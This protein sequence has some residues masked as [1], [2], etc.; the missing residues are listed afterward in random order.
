MSP[1]IQ[2]QIPPHIRVKLPGETIE[3]LESAL[4]ELSEWTCTLPK[5][6]V[7][8]L[9]AIPLYRRLPYRVKE[10][11]QLDLNIVDALSDI[12][13]LL[14]SQ[15]L[16]KSWRTK[17]IAEGL[18]YS[19]ETWNLT[20]AASAA[21]AL[22]ETACAWCV[23]SGEI[24][25]T[26]QKQRS[27]QIR[28]AQDAL[29]IRNALYDESF[30][31]TWGTRQP[32]ML[33]SKN[34]HPARTLQRKNIITMIQKA[35]KL[36][37]RERL[38][39]GYEVLCDAVHPS[40]GANEVF[41]VEGGMAPEIKRMRVLLN[42]ESVGQIDATDTSQVRPG[43][44]LSRIILTEGAWALRSLVSSFKV[45]D[46][47]CRDIFMTAKLYL[48]GDMNYW[49]VLP[50]SGKYDL[51]PCGSGRKSKFCSHKFGPQ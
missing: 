46:N 24:A 3:D 1:T 26:W 7:F 6:S 5:E 12:H 25:A 43:S 20:M 49:G 22:I 37:S 32:H 8:Y 47:T 2:L 44:P 50:R 27:N 40:W 31:M 51:C 39:K 30:Q 10:I 35:E 18:K 23:E 21:R 29:K 48:L 33:K 15:L 16:C 34:S 45:F 9:N 41:W 36:L 42:V 38:F 19:L 17:Q 14:T 28:V 11:S 13:S 4:S